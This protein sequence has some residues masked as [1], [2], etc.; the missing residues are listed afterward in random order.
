MEPTDTDFA[1]ITPLRAAREFAR[2]KQ[3]D[4][5]EKSGVP[6]GT[7]SRIERGQVP[8]TTIALKLARALGASVEELF[9]HALTEDASD[10]APAEADSP[11]RGPS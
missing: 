4:L 11:A 7:I 5:A 6:Q 2:W 8:H 9:G 10:D 1:P 3:D